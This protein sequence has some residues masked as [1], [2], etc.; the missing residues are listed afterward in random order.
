MLCTENEACTRWCPH[1]RFQI[2][3]SP[4]DSTCYYVNNRYAQTDSNCV[5]HNCM[6]WRWS[7][8][9]NKRGY[10]GLAGKGE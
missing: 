6:A 2:Q 10:C 8:T 9:D 1:I 4:Y 3:K 5:G 7:L